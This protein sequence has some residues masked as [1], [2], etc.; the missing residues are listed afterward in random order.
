MAEIVQGNGESLRNKIRREW[1]LLNHVK[2]N[3]GRFYHPCTAVL[4]LI[5]SSKRLSSK[6]SRDHTGIVPPLMYAVSFNGCI[7]ILRFTW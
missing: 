6:R 1:I 5:G 4:L 3:G 2:Y 7:Y